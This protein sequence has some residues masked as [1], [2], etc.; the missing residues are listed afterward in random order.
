MYQSFLK[1]ILHRNFHFQ[2]L[3]PVH[4]SKRLVCRTH[5]YDKHHRRFDTEIDDR[6]DAYLLILDLDEG[7]PHEHERPIDDVDKRDEELV[8]EVVLEVVDVHARG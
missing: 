6:D 2:F 8:L 5:P 3:R 1:L 4:K 7:G